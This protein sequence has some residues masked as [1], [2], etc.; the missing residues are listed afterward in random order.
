MLSSQDKFE[1]FVAGVLSYDTNLLHY[2]HHDLLEDTIL[3]PLNYTIL[4][5][6]E[7]ASEV[8]DK[9]S[10]VESLVESATQDWKDESYGTSFLEPFLTSIGIYYQF[11]LGV[12]YQFLFGGFYKTVGW[13]L[14]LVFVDGKETFEASTMAETG[15][16]ASGGIPLHEFRREVPPGWSPNLP[17]YPLRL[18]FE[19]LKLW[20]RIYDGADEL[21]GPLVAGRLQGKAQRLSMQ[22]RLPRPDGSVDVGSD[23]LV[24]LSVEEVRDPVDPNVVLQ[25]AIP[26]GVQALCNAPRDTFGMSDQ[27][28]V[29]R[30]IEDLFEFRRGKLTLAEYS[31]EFDA[32]LEEAVTRAV[33][34]LNDVGRFYLFFRGSGLSQKFID[35]VKLQIQGDL[36]RF[37]EARALALRLMTRK[38]DHGDSYYKNDEAETPDEEA[39][40]WEDSFWAEDGW[41]WVEDTWDHGDLGDWIYDSWYESDDGWYGEG[42]DEYYDE[43]ADYQGEMA[44]ENDT[45]ADSNSETPASGSENFP[46][47]GGKGGLS[48]AICGSRWHSTSSCPVGKGEGKGGSPKGSSK[49]YGKSFGKGKKGFGKFRGKGKGKWVPRKGYGKGKAKGYHGYAEKTLIHS[50][51]ENMHA[52]SPL[53]PKSRTVHFR[54]DHDDNTPVLDLGRSR[55]EPETAESE[56]VPAPEKRLDFTFA[57]NIYSS[58]ATFHTVRGEKRRGLLVDPGAASGLVGSET[59]RDLM[60]CCIDDSNKDQVRW[61][62]DRS[63]SVS[64]IS[65]TPEATLG[66]VHL[67]ISLAGAKGLFSADVLGGEGSLCPALLSNP[68]LRKRRA[69]ILCDYFANGDGL[70]VVP[71][72]DRSWSDGQGPGSWHYMRTLLTDSGHYLLPVDDQRTVSMQTQKDVEKHLFTWSSEAN[73]I[74]SDVRHC[75][76]QQKA[77]RMCRERERCDHG[78]HKAGEETDSN[79]KETT[80]STSS[81]TMSPAS[82]TKSVT[83]TA[84]E[85]TSASSLI[86]DDSFLT[87]SNPETTSS[88]S[89]GTFIKDVHTQSGVLS[90]EDVHTQSGVLSNADKPFLDAPSTPPKS[91]PTI[92]SWSLEGN[93]LVRHHSVPRRMLFTP[94]CANDCPVSKE[95]FVGN[96][97]TYL[98]L[99]PKRLGERVLQDD[100]RK[101]AVPNKDME[102]LWIGRTVFKLREPRQALTTKTTT[103]TASVDD[104]LNSAEF[105]NYGGDM[106]PEHWTDEQKT[107][108]H[109]KYR[110][111][112]EEF[113]TK[114]GRKPVTPKNVHSWFQKASGRGLQWQF[115]ELRS[116]SG[117]LSLMMMAASMSVGFPVDYRYGWDLAYPAHQ[118]VLR[119]C[120]EEFCP[121]HLFE[122]PTC[123]PWSVASSSK[124]PDIRLQERQSELPTL[125]FLDE[126]N[127]YQHNRN[128]GFAVEQPSGSAML[129]DSPLSRLRDL[130]GVRAWRL[131][132]CMLGAQCDQGHPIRKPTSLLSNRRWKLVIKRCDSH[133]GAPHGVLQGQVRGI[134]RTALAAVYPKRMCLLY[135]QDLWAILRKDNRRSTKPWPQQLL[136][137]HDLYYSCERCQ[138][139]RAALQAANIPWFQDNVATVSLV[140]DALVLRPNMRHLRN[141]RHLRYH[142]LLRISVREYQHHRHLR[143]LQLRPRLHFRR[144]KS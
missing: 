77:E 19:R 109:K 26:S 41:Q 12:Y 53:K 89:S 71:A 43:H 6:F 104:E 7:E 2:E 78:S 119:Q 74:W 143:N 40:A 111:M 24:R 122:A 99:V 54:L 133:R 21:V 128:L 140:S 37:Q 3:E 110:A 144:Q 5:D 67:P 121:A 66:E 132:Q 83:T 9:S 105:P 139:G 70:L 45:V 56:A 48:C 129:V 75:F 81:G 138:L 16:G 97:T 51:N 92:D 124:P 93:T 79:P 29:S 131:D 106:F 57:T 1:A 15:H 69:S 80:S 18:Y 120:H 85:K 61:C 102:Q 84:S 20:Y 38:D 125:E 68:A 142:N 65:G 76:L 30:A 39:A 8:N 117:R 11:S 35:D 59:L 114:S 108:M 135:G 127:L 42:Y 126:I 87:G 46:M 34:E 32:R 33:L 13:L 113:Y 4:R 73:E 91:L 100:W 116:G 82:V 112:P 31:I 115:W 123:T 64:G 25:R 55:P 47:K 58:C 36:R 118:A 23:A 130:G 28:M 137:V 52:R 98:Q 86:S 63:N 10:S 107:R 141:Q 60:E 94:N 50:F 136:W 22:L 101:S 44:E 90:N 88:T 27:E 17:D 95:M 72:E 134:N 14:S 62:H 103:T 96:R 49:G